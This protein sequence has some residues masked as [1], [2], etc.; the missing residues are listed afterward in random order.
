MSF[1]DLPD[2]KNSLKLDENPKAIGIF[3][4]DSISH[5]GVLQQVVE[6]LELSGFASAEEIKSEWFN[7]LQVEMEK[8]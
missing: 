3:F 6:K 5:N 4:D 2:Y 1:L 7:L 8:K